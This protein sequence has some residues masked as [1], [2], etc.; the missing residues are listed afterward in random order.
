MCFQAGLFE[1]EQPFSNK[2]AVLEAEPRDLH[3]GVR[4]QG[5]TKVYIPYIYIYMDAYRTYVR[6]CI[7]LAN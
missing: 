1:E 6:F 4:I 2:K 3:A 7:L 5:L